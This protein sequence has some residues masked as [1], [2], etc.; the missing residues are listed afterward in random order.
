[1]LNHKSFINKVDSIYKAKK[2]TGHFFL[3]YMDISEFQFVNRYYGIEKGDRLLH[4]IETLLNRIPE[5]VAFER[6]FSDHFIAL[7]FTTFGCTKDIVLS[8]YKNYEKEFLNEQKKNYPACNLKISCGIYVLE[9]DNISDAIDLANLARKAA[10]KNGS[11][12]A[13]VFDRAML[14]E[15]SVYRE[16]EEAT[17]LA[18]QERRFT[19]FLQPKVN[20][21]T[22]EIIGAEALARRINK[23]GDLIFPDG[24]FQIL[25]DNGA[26][27]ELDTLIL[28]QVC[29]YISDRLKN[30]VSVV[31]TSVNL[32]RLHIQNSNAADDF[33]SIVQ[34]YHVPPEY[35]EFELTETILLN[36]FEGAKLLI[37]RLRSY[38]YHVSID[39][40]GAGYAG[41]NIWQ[42][43]NFDILKLDKKFLAE[44][45]PIKSRNA[46]IV[47]NVI[48]IA[49]RLG[50]EVLCEGVETEE[51][52]Q[53]LIKLGCTCVQGYYFSRPVP[54]EQFY[55][56]Y[57]ELN[58]HYACP[59]SKQ[60]FTFNSPSKPAQKP[61]FHGKAPQHVLLLSLCALF[62][63][64]CVALTL[65]IFYRNG[66]TNI[67]INSINR[68]LESHSSGQSA[69]IR[70]KIDD[71]IS[72]L[73]TFSTL[74]EHEDNNEF[75]D[76][77]LAALNESEPEITFLFS[78]AEE[79]DMRTER[80]DARSIDV[81]YIERL[82][83]GEVV[84]SDITFSE[85]AGN[86]Y[87][88]SIGV[89]VF[90]DGEFIGGLRAIVNANI[91]V[92]AEHY[93]S[94]YGTVENTFVTDN[95]GKI[96]LANKDMNAFQAGNNITE[97]IRALQLSNDASLKLQNAL[98][99]ESI[100]T[101]F[102][103]GE[104]NGIPYYASIISLDY[105]NWKT[106]VIFKANEIGGIV[107]SLFCYTVVSSFGLVIA[108]LVISIAVTLYLLRWNKKI[109]R[110][111]ERYLLLEEFSD[112]VLFDYDK[113]KDIIRFTPNAQQLFD[114][115]ELTHRGFL[116]HLEQFP[117]IHSTDYAAIK[118]ILTCQ[119]LEEKGEVRIR[120]RHPSD[121]HFYWYLA[122]YK[123]MHSQG[124]IVSIIG[125]IVNIDEQQ[126]YEE[127]LIKQTM[128]DGLTD[129]YNKSASEYLVHQCLEED[130]TGMLFM[131]D[132]DDFKK[133]NDTH[134]HPEG[135]YTLQFVSRCLKR[136]FRSYDIIGRIGGDELL[137]YMR[138]INSSSLVH[139]KMQTFW[140]QM[141]EHSKQNAM[142]LTVSVGIVSYPD[143]GQSFEELYKKAD[144]L[145]YNAKLNGKQS[146]C[147]EGQ[148]YRFDT[149]PDKVWEDGANK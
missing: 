132:I 33:H 42:E 118:E 117:N 106:V 142:L 24:F 116:E 4:A 8:T 135:D 113:V 122:Q 96:L 145:M 131:I 128:R 40:F 95:S 68:N 61:I 125:K 48:N 103:L 111:T 81:E 22:G 72:T 124:R 109:D 121:G 62:L 76:I 11:Y 107:H 23:N 92:D 7:A 139:K 64:I 49:Q 60:N 82:K 141:C 46:A 147:F 35:I 114:V 149:V 120:L 63:T 3:L 74:I 67:F 140:K 38:Q 99:N 25:E 143:D 100:S 137:V 58:G 13:V 136:I 16:K 28:E 52:C 2:N 148:I 6:V 70:A 98:S 91:L 105:N 112:T 78:T 30:G 110:D 10:K 17:N 27:V 19:F 97:Y 36:E 54:K 5:I 102:R 79:F 119:S 39:D 88:F 80:G 26:I 32:S 43:L 53:Y 87:C 34:K 93:L 18:L 90:S 84:L 31:R 104:S 83:R 138:K 94:P 133:I 126:K 55:K 57:K 127:A 29:A 56:T 144:Q 37:D 85:L 146:Y 129:L 75:I 44:E 134:G 59:F 21:L 1:M 12:N 51:Q 89:P 41:I 9:E 71:V 108:I 69:L 65:G 73:I 115:Q 15:I 123:Y 77:Y 20:L 130:K 50:I 14:N 86:I 45:E 66:V 101:S 47:P